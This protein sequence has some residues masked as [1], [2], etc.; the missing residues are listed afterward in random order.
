[1][2]VEALFRR[3]LSKELPG[4]GK[5][6][7]FIIYALVAGIA[8]FVAWAASF[9]L[10]QVA[11]AYGEVI[12]VTRVQVIQSVDGGVLDELAVREGDRVEPGQVLA[13]LDQARFG[14]AVT[15]IEARLAALRAKAR[16]LRAEVVRAPRVDFPEA[17]Q[18]FPELVRL[19]QALFEQRR[20]NLR[21]RSANLTQALQLAEEEL[22]LVLSLAANNDVNR[23]EV[24]T[25]ERAVNQAQAKIIHLESE[26]FESA[27]LEL[28]QAEDHIAQNEQILKQRLEQLEASVF[29]AKVSGVVKNIRV[30][31]VG[32][33]LRPGEELMQIIPL[34]D[35]LLVEAKASPADIAQ[36]RPGL[37]ATLRFDPY[38]YTIYGG[39]EG[40]VVYVS[41]DTLKEDTA[42]GQEIY[43]RVHVAP[44]SQPVA[45]TTGSPIDMM[46]GMTAQVD[47]KTSERTLLNY[48]LKPVRKTLSE[49]FG[50]R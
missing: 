3:D 50:E 36:I 30:T 6:Q 15:E 43:Y 42:Q 11:R 24:I 7:S 13:R 39:V 25:A 44:S 8:G 9:N 49:A 14:A 38:D 21:A 2:W 26:F 27:R 28:S 10:D 29:V 34:G 16:R 35:A 5:G 47:I 41:A 22:A 20:A 32:G 1:M 45:T 48:L 33:V 31:T 4:T 40:Q 19:E 17:I 46:P 12:A 37:P 23:A 18:T